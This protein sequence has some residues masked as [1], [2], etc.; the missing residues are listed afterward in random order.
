MGVS[1]VLPQPTPSEIRSMIRRPARLA[2]VQYEQQTDSGETLADRILKDVPRGSSGLP[3]LQFT[4]RKLYDERNASGSLTY[5]AYTSLGAAGC[6]AAHA[7]SVFSELAVHEQQ[8]FAVVF[9]EL[10]RVSTDDRLPARQRCRLSAFDGNTAAMG[11]VQALISARL[12]V[13]DDEHG[14]SAVELVHESLLQTWPRLRDWL[15]I[16]GEL[17]RKRLRLLEACERWSQSQR[18]PDLLLPRGTALDEA[19]EVLSAGLLSAEHDGPSLVR[20][21]IRQSQRAV[22]RIQRQRRR[23]ADLLADSQLKSLELSIDSVSDSL[24]SLE[25]LAAKE[26][27]ADRLPNTLQYLHEAELLATT[28]RAEVLRQIEERLTVPERNNRADSGFAARLQA[29][30]QRVSDSLFL[31]PEYWRHREANILR[32]FPELVWRRNLRQSVSEATISPDRK[33]LLL[34]TTENSK[35]IAIVWD[36]EKHADPLPHPFQ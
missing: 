8:V 2:G 30:R 31:D 12:L 9:R 11:L 35:D 27:D 33:R 15:S 22:Q 14:V 32:E 1:D 4:L 19:N 28:R 5:R 29:L 23:A 17:L 7:E 21:F 3:L 20:R 6:V 25:Q 34:I 16:E 10:V 13:A 36:L 24:E 18:T 26:L